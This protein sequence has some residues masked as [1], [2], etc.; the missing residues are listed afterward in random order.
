MLD[1]SIKVW[2]RVN[3]VPLSFP[4]VLFVPK[5]TAARS[6][7]LG[8]WAA[9]KGVEKEGECRK[10]EP[11]RQNSFCRAGSQGRAFAAAL[12][13]CERSELMYVRL[14]QISPY[15]IAAEQNK[16]NRVSMR[17]FL[18]QWTNQPSI[19]NSVAV[20]FK[21][22]F[23][24]IFPP[25]WSSWNVPLLSACQL[26]RGRGVPPPHRPLQFHIS[27]AVRGLHWL[28]QQADR[29]PISW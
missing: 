4:C 12:L 21:N 20:S 29:H 16:D 1:T 2:D 25:F 7:K 5:A 11:E 8:R 14:L 17:H 19:F 24:P 18:A 6:K 9:D 15:Q 22:N 26:G 23:L 13:C 3:T 28:R 27:P 10:Q